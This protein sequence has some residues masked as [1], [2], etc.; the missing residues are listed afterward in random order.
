MKMM[1]NKS[2]SDNFKRRK[3]I[4]NLFMGAGFLTVKDYF[5]MQNDKTKMI[6][7]PEQER[8]LIIAA[9]PDDEAKASSLIFCERKL[10]DKLIILVMRLVGEGPPSDREKWTPDEAINIRSAEMGKSAV[11]LNADE[12]RW[13]K[14]P[15]PGLENIKKTPEN[16]A[17]MVSLL[18]EIK[19]TKIIT[20]WGLGD[21]HPD[22]AGTA[23]LVKEA[24][25]QAEISNVLK[26]IYYYGQPTREK[27]L[28]NFIP[29]YFVDISNP[30]ILA[31]VLWTFCIHRSQSSFHYIDESLK[32]YK[33]Y[34]QNAGFEYADAFMMNY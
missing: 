31:S 28:Q 24:I 6:K 26:A 5:P 13:W 32:Y 18:N 22:H 27:E 1:V 10:S 9:H 19:P 30:S 15:K 17:R 14:T 29:N 11:F 33:K 7:Q 3:F 12:L 34:G 2:N 21:S 16:V 20:H 4:R 23:E 8:W 25:K